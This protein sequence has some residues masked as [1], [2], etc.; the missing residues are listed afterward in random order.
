MNTLLTN[1]TG[2]AGSRDRG[3]LVPLSILAAAGL[4]LAPS[5]TLGQ[6]WLEIP[7]GEVRTLAGPIEAGSGGVEV[8][9][10]GN[11]Y[12]ADFG[13]HLSQGPMGTKVFRVTPVGDVSVFAEGFNGASGN[14]ID[15]E[16][17]FF[18]ANIAGNT[19]SRVREDGSIETVVTEGLVNP[20]GI[21]FG[22]DGALM[23]ANC[24]SHQVARVERSGRA[25][26]F[27]ESNLFRCPNGLVAGADGEFYASNF[28]NGDVLRIGPDGDVSV[29]ATLPG[30][31]LGHLIYSEGMLYVVARSAHQ[32]YEVN[33]TGEH[34]VL[35]GSGDHGIDDGPA[36]EATLSFPN[37][38]GLS[39]DGRV[40]YWNDVAVIVEDGGQ[41]LAPT[42]IRM[43]RLR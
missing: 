9:A 40:L 8:D 22:V 13:R 6:A 32:I 14:A 21:A 36:L 7:V 12:T 39:P 26:V 42:V 33:L 15:A 28:Y 10:Q 35:A 20:V 43:L 2:R 4:L 30:G 17:R 38:L 29:L 23:V 24:G 3:R 25:L 31:N 11:V 19:I 34:K 41:T 18:Q 16:G 5:A 37:D 27:A 1:D